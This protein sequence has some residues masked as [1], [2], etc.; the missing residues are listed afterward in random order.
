MT[1]LEAI[2]AAANGSTIVSRVGER[3]TPSILAPIWISNGCAAYSS[4]DITKEEREGAWEIA[5]VNNAS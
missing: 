1:L 4:A 3:Y 2:N 5:T